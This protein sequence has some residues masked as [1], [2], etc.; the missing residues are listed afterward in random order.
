ME[1]TCRLC[2]QQRPIHQLRRS[3]DDHA[4][5]IQQKLIDCCRWNSLF[6]IEYETLPK[7]ICHP[8]YRRLEASWAF[9]ESVAQAQKQLISKFGD[10]KPELLPIEHVNIR[11][12]DIKDEPNGIADD[13]EQDEAI[14]TNQPSK[15]IVL[16]K[17]MKAETLNVPDEKTESHGQND[18]N[19]IEKSEFPETNC[20]DGDA[21]EHFEQFDDSDQSESTDEEWN[22]VQPKMPQPANTKKPRYDARNIDY[23]EIRRKRFQKLPGSLSRLCD[24]CGM[25]FSNVNTLRR[26]V[27]THSGVGEIAKPLACKTCGKRFRDNY[28]LKVKRIRNNM[29][30]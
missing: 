7:R 21:D 4:L 17:L 27:I 19:A 11:S 9:A 28:N 10:E 20:N 2:A 26:H 18:E 23:D 5:N 30:F 12:E 8:C 24:T 1:T 29:H 3:F 22:V 14:E 25:V 13:D 6:P 15:R 16:N